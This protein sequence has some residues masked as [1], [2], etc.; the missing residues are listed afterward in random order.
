[1]VELKHRFDEDG[2]VP[3]PGFL[4]SRELKKVRGRLERY[5]GE[6]CPRLEPHYVLF[7]IDNSTRGIKQLIEMNKFD[8]FF[9]DLLHGDKAKEVA[10]GLLD[11]EVLPQQV[12]YFDKS[13]RIGT[14]T[15]P[16]QDGFYFCITPNEALTMWIAL[17]DC[18]PENGCMKYLRGSHRKGVLDHR[19]SG[20][21]GFS[22]GLAETPWSQDEVATL[23]ARAGD[24]LVHHSLT[25]HFA[26]ANRS[27]RHRRS[28]GLTYYAARTKRDEL[29]WEQYR[30]SLNAQREKYRKEATRL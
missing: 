11:D 28:L 3:I 24:C 16:H 29:A 6:V 19:A 1:M 18:D 12:L 23:P 27:D 10:R 8:D 20:A 5:I 13:P 17:D 9:A 26:D 25:I 7:D 2:F 22:Q 30:A 15:P 21:V 14:P 4:E